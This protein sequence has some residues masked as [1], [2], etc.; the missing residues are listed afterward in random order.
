MEKRQRPRTTARGR[1]RAALL[2]ALSLFA[3]AQLVLAL[4]VAAVRDLPYWYKMDRLKRRSTAP[5]RPLTVVVLGSSRTLHG[6]QAASLE[7]PL[8]RR[9]GRPVVVFNFGLVGAGPLRE[10]LTL[11]RLL[12]DGVRPDLV[13]VEVL[14]PLLA[15]QVPFLEVRLVQDPVCRLR[16]QDLD[17]VE[18]YGGPPPGEL[19][20]AWAATWLLPCYYHRLTLVSRVFPSLLPLSHRLDGFRGLNGSG[21]AAPLYQ[22]EQRSKALA[23]AEQEY[24]LWLNGFRLGGFGPRALEEILQT[25]RRER[26]AAALV[27]M[28]EGPVF[29]SWYQGQSWQ[30]INEFLDGLSRRTGAPLFSA[31]DWFGEDD[32]VDSHHMLHQGSARFTER[33][34]R[35]LIAPLLSRRREKGAATAA[36]AFAGGE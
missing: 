23:V 22:A 3:L 33:L 36:R 29:R 7:A 20:R 18:R 11:R 32:F 1:A 4:Q 2:S 27:V 25:C 17:P 5:G 14:P 35:E 15:G 26:I 19:R 9:L 8:S 10:L 13:L 16:A 30:E 21:D 24:R 31:R 34:G 12:A 28:P 6:L